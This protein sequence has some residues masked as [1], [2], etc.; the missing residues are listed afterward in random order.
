[1]EIKQTYTVNGQTFDTKKEAKLYL[2]EK[3]LEILID[4]HPN[5]DDFNKIVYFE[6]WID[7]GDETVWDSQWFTL[8]DALYDMDTNNNY[9]HTLNKKFI[10]KVTIL[11]EK[12][13]KL[14]IDRKVIF[15][16]IEN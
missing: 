4:E 16:L 10:I 9:S 2:K 13:G 6:N 3:Q 11:K 8:E 1:M 5:G 15:E 12:S 14:M 7:D